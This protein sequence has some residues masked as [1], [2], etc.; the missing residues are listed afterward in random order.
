MKQDLLAPPVV[1]PRVLR[2]FA[3]VVCVLAAIAGGV[4]G[5]GMGI[6]WWGW[7]GIGARVGLVVCAAAAWVWVSVRL[8]RASQRCRPERMPLLHG[9]FSVLGMLFFYLAMMI[10]LGGPS[11]RF[12]GMF[13][14][15]LILY[16]AMI[17]GVMLIGGGWARRVGESL[18]CPQCEY[19]FGFANHDD[20]PVRCPE[21]GKGWLGRLKKGRK[22]RSVR[23]MAA[24]LAVG[25]VGMV[26]SSPVFYIHGL[27]PHLPTPALYA[28]VYVSPVGNDAAWKEMQTRTLDESWSR[29]LEQRV[30]SNRTEWSFADGGGRWMEFRLAAGSTDDLTRDRFYRE[31]FQADVVVPRSVRVGEEFDVALRVS[32]AADA[33]SMK[34]MVMFGGYRV[35]MG[36]FVRRS[37]AQQWGHEL[38]PRALH[39]H[40]NM[41]IHRVCAE[42]VRPGEKLTIQAV[43]WVIF[44]PGYDRTAWKHDDTP[45]PLISA[46][47]FERVELETEV[48]V[49]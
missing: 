13:L 28:M 9:A 2:R 25:V 20:A 36:P 12:G 21:C 8:V 23:M 43:Y 1:N 42:G 34:L 49:K 15:Q 32:R 6:P 41:F 37:E 7:A 29:R 5:W 22:V 46:V 44:V 30:L 19:E 14:G 10:M 11:G 18:H 17:C 35:G 33:G 24:G 48:R 27:A 38:R 31:A 3:A 45:M 39:M 26:A 40:K 16:A 47:W 4:M